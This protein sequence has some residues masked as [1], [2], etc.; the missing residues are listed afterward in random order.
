MLFTDEQSLTGSF[1]LML[2]SAS[3][4]RRPDV[5]SGVGA[6]DYVLAFD[7]LWASLPFARFSS[8][9]FDAS[10]DLLHKT[11][12]GL[13]GRTQTNNE[14]FQNPFPTDIDVFPRLTVTAGGPLAARRKAIETVRTVRQLSGVELMIEAVQSVSHW[15]GP[16][17]R[18]MNQLIS[19]LRF[20]TPL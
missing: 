12:F 14:N 4:I 13:L 9:T 6:D 7:L 1:P 8:P 3:S 16:A 15:H 17:Y 5:P 20:L 11:Q 19:Q 2:F 18:F 10:Y